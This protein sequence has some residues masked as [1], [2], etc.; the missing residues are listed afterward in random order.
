M[1]NKRVAYHECIFQIRQNYALRSE[2]GIVML[3][4]ERNSLSLFSAESAAE[5]PRESGPVG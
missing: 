5:R 2:Q 4:F 3:T 1:E